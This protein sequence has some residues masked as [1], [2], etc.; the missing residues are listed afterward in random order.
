MDLLTQTKVIA[1]TEGSDGLFWVDPWSRDGQ[2]MAVRMRPINAALRLHAEAAIQ[3][4]SEAR[5][6]YP[7]T[8]PSRRP[9]TS[10]S[11]SLQQRSGQPAYSYASPTDPVNAYPSA[12]TKL[13]EP[14]ALD[15]M[16][17]GARRIDFFGLKFQLAD[18]MEQSY[19]RAL[20]AQASSDPKLHRTVSREL[21][22]INGV[23]GRLQDIAETYAQL[24]DLFA[25]TWLRTNRPS[26]LRFALDHYDRAVDLWL[27]RVDTVRSA[28]R[29]YTE[30]KTLPSAAS[31]GIPEASQ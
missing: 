19:Q 30:S 10:S 13:R 24:R 26:G 31:L 11:I 21:S 5:A 22:D 29:Q 3:L 2:K 27:E 17:F 6:A 20:I 18:E 12:P 28:Q 14:N 9:Q 4:I 25:Q 23:N 16:E 1:V 8:Q 15:A 7:E